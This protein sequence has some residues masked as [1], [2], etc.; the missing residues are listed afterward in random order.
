MRMPATAN[1]KRQPAESGASAAPGGDWHALTTA[2]ALRQLRADAA[3]LSAAEAAARLARHGAN[4]LPQ[5]PRRGPLRRLAAQFD[6]LLIHLLIASAALVAAIGHWLDSAVILAVVLVNALIGFIQE[7]R[8]ERALDSIRAL[9][10]LRARALR[11]GLPSGL[12]AEQLVPGD[13]VL[14]EAGD[15]IPA[16]LRLLDS[17]NL[18]LDESM[19]SG[20]SLPVDKSSA[21]VAAD[22][23]LAE[24]SSLAYAGCLVAAGQARGL[25]VATGADSELGRIGALVEQVEPLSTPLLRQLERFGRRLTA[26]ILA[27]AAALFTFGLLARDYSAGEMLLA[28]VGIAVA[29]VPEGLPAVVTIALAI[30]V[31]RMAGQRAIVRRLPAVETLGTVSCICSDKT[32]TLTR[33]EMTAQRLLTAA[34][35]YSLSGGG[36][37]PRGEL[38]PDHGAAGDAA[39]LARIARCAALC[40][41]ARLLA[42]DAEHAHWRIEGDPTEA[43]LLVLARKLG[44]DESAVQAAHPRRALIPFS[45]EARYMATLHPGRDGHRLICLKGAPERLLACCTSELGDDGGSRPLDADAWHAR[46]EALAGRGLRLLALAEL[47]PAAGE[48]GD[49]DLAGALDAGGACLLG[50]VGLIDP[51]REEALQAVAECRAAGI[52]VRMI[53]GDHAGT[54]AAIGAQLGLAGAPLTGRDIDRLDDAALA[55]RLGDTEVF[56]RTSPE[57]KLRLVRALQAGGEVVAMTGDG[58]NDAPALRRADIGVAMGGKGSEAA[59]EA[60]EVVLADDNFASIVRAVREGRTV[61]A[62]VRKAILFMLPTN[63]GEALALVLAILLGVDLPVTPLQILWVNMV[64]AV[65]LAIALAFEPREPRAMTRPPRD[66]REPLLDLHLLWR[67]L[68]VALLM[69]AICGGLFLWALADGA[70]LPL[71]RSLAVNALVACE[72]AYLFASRRLYGAVL[73]RDG[74]LGNRIA[75][76]AVAAL[77]ALQLGFTYLPLSQ[78]LFGV[79]PLGAGHWLLILPLATGLLLLVE[80]EKALLR[81]RG[82]RRARRDN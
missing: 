52:R 64:T 44:L 6:N 63:A 76:L 38:Q 35:D 46:L 12:P 70:D 43:A 57:H 10:T 5:A 71:A 79:A 62:N 45:A 74:L 36:Y 81:R 78:A 66:P 15:R 39:P 9:L 19:L 49:G 7:G 8:A 68:F 47:E 58:V 16:D 32:G 29:A 75:L 40:N 25:V 31:Q 48:A 56:A 17:H 53:T 72:I 34:G 2:E 69:V 24:R 30:G 20:E 33:N 55:A 54:A 67:L 41:D 80:A 1:D 28:A 51:L 65:T 27:L 82:R 13:V 73:N 59:V 42:P 18:R 21:A 61:Y 26:A 3:G 23:P 60:A 14:I 37:A 22:A 4:R 50:V 11:D 77:L